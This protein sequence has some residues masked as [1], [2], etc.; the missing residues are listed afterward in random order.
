M[1]YDVY[2]QWSGKH[3]WQR[4]CTVDHFQ[5]ACKQAGLM[6]AAG[7]HRVKVYRYGNTLV[8]RLTREDI[9]HVAIPSVTNVLG[10][11]QSRRRL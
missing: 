2:L 7:A 9:A 10:T 3:P 6:L 5:E 1:C 4:G 8:T 11:E